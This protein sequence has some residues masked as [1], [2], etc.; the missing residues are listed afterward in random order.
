[1]KLFGKKHASHIFNVSGSSVCS[2][3][4]GETCKGRL[5]LYLARLHVLR[6]PFTIKG[7]LWNFEIQGNYLEVSFCLFL[8]QHH[9]LWYRGKVAVCAGG[10]EPETRW[11][12]LTCTKTYTHVITHTHTQAPKLW[13]WNLK[14]SEQL[15]MLM[16]IVTLFDSECPLR[17]LARRSDKQPAPRS[18]VWHWIEWRKVLLS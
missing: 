10:A 16:I 7:G 13:E 17:H 4:A 14:Q 2:S 11:V 1:M 12:G 5:S 8:S 6:F 3:N 15:D 18:A 9:H